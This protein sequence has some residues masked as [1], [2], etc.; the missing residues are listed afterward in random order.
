MPF[1]Q[2]EYLVRQYRRLKSEELR[3]GKL[4]ELMVCMA[5]DTAELYSRQ[6]GIK[7]LTACIDEVRLAKQPRLDADLTM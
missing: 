4:L 5:S 1:S 2:S 6:Q 3:I 7:Y